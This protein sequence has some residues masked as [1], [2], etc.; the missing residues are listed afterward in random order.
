MTNE[1]I[2]VEPTS[3][4]KLE[5]SDAKPIKTYDILNRFSMDASMQ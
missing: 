1:K 3:E 5:D 2:R 4:M